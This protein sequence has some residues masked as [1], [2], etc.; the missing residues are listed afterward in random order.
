MTHEE[1]VNWLLCAAVYGEQTGDEAWVERNMEVFADGLASMMHR[2]NPDA[3]RGD[4]VMSLDSSRTLGGAEITTYDSLDVSLGQARGNLYLAVKCWAA[5]VALEHL[6][7]ETG[8]ETQMLLAGRQ[9]ER[10]AATVVSH[11]T[12]EGYIPAVLD[13]ENRSRIIPAIEGLVFPLFTHCPDALDPDGRFGELI[14][15]LKRHLGTVLARGA[16]LFEDGGWKISSTSDNSF[17]SKI[18]LCQFVAR[19]IFG[20]PWGEDG[21][22]AD[23][24]HV[25]W[26]TDPELSYWSYSDQIVAG[27]IRGSKYYPRGV[28]SI[29]WLEE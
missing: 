13:G 17:L 7:Q 25:R 3:E 4:G 14:R 12:D 10:C 20:L 2:D 18:Y 8:R 15:A 23:A 29:L 28:T 26:L 19:R 27:R 9:A 1:L 21:A 11:M 22:R 5:Y 16:C 24:V 6:F